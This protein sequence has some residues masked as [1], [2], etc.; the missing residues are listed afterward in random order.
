IGIGHPEAT[1]DYSRPLAAM[2]QFLDGLDTADHPVPRERRCLAALGPKMLDLC[3]E[4]SLGS[5]SYFVPVAH[6]RAARERLGAGR[7]LAPELA[8][9]LGTDAEAC[10][11][12]ARGYAE[13]YL[14]LGNYTRNLLNHGFSED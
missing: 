2:R 3:A 4:R 12:T 6:T 14:R 1:R 10:R 5:H 8:C 9:V 13:L 7:L 11:G